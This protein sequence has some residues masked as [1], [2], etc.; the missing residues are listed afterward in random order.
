MTNTQIIIQEVENG[1][2]VQCLEHGKIE[3]TAVFLNLE[4]MLEGIDKYL[5]SVYEKVKA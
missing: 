3:S 4:E 2:H 5:Y 1:F